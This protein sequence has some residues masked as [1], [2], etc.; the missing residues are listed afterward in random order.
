MAAEAAVVV[1]VVEKVSVGAA[2]AADRKFSLPSRR[3]WRGETARA[4]T[5]HPLACAAACWLGG[6]PYW[7]DS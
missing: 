7:A 1:A 5:L 4:Y 3:S 2:V 6:G